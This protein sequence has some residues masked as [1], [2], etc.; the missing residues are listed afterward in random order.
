MPKTLAALADRHDLYQRSVQTPDRDIRWICNAYRALA[1]RDLRTF[2]EDFCGTAA[3]SCAF[4]KRHP[5]NHAIGVDLDGPTLAWGEARNLSALKPAARERVRLIQ[6]DVRDVTRPKV[7]LLAA[8]NFSWFI[9]HT[10]AELGAYFKNCRKSL[11]PGG[12]LF[13]DLWGGSEAHACHS[14]TRRLKGFTYTWDQEKFD[15]IGGKTLAHIHFGFR[16]GSRL[17]RAFTYDW[18]LWSLPETQDLLRD[19][20]FEDVHVYWEGAH[21]ESGKGTG[22]FRRRTAGTPDLSYV[23]YVMARN[24]AR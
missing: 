8:A 14:E 6:A 13:L 21:A 15:P 9:F 12:W 10:R 11:A 18:R 24:P 4:V 16:D 20:G 22:I 7:D 17:D 23:A 3:L 2:R 5:D 19:V 1:G